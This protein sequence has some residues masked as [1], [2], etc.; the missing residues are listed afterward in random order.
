[1]PH[2]TGVGFRCVCP[3]LIYNRSMNG[4][5]INNPCGCP[6]SH[7][8]PIRTPLSTPC[9]PFLFP[10]THPFTHHSVVPPPFHRFQPNQSGR[11][12]P[13]PTFRST[14]SAPLPQMFIISKD[15]C[16]THP[17]LSNRQRVLRLASISFLRLPLIMPLYHSLG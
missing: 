14:V 2:F 5:G 11:G 10:T 9:T 7:Y 3:A 6:F 15:A 16:A 13:A 4:R 8:S 1:M 12:N 17:I